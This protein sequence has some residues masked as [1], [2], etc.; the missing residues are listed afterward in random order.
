MTQLI[1]LGKIRFFFAGTWSDATT[2]ELNDVV[3]Y[4]GNVYVYTYALASQGYLPTNTN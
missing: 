1:D 2:Y 3:K 4:G